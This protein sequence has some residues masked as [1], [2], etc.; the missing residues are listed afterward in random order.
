V[1]KLFKKNFFDKL[2]QTPEISAEALY[3]LG[4]SNDVEGVTDH[5]FHLT[6]IEELAPPAKD[7]EVAERL[8]EITLKLLGIEEKI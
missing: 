4:V 7:I 2:S 6:K 5:F 8:W 3:Y 1:Y